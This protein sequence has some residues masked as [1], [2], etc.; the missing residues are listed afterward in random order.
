[1]N[2][3]FEDEA[4][5]NPFDFWKG[6]S[7]K[8]KVRKVAG[9]I[10]YDKSHFEAA[11]VLGEDEAM[12]VIWKTQQSLQQFVAED[13]FKSPEELSERLTRVLGGDIR[14]KM[15]SNPPTAESHMPVTEDTSSTS[16]DTTET[17]EDAFLSFESLREGD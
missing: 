6:A 13:Q 2:P 11:S 15:N 7:F 17:S 14:G 3:E 9:Y 4:A 5:I 10:N 8:L 12:E 1:M 16:S